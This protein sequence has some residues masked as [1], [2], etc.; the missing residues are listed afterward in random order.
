MDHRG[1]A[2]EDPFLPEMIDNPVGRGQVGLDRDFLGSPA[3]LSR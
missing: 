2:H 3:P 1:V